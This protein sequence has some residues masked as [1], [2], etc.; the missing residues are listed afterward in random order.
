MSCETIPNKQKTEQSETINKNLESN[1][2]VVPFSYGMHSRT[3]TPLNWP[4]F[5]YATK[6]QTDSE[7]QKKRAH[8]KTVHKKSGC[9]FAFVNEGKSVVGGQKVPRLRTFVFM[10]ICGAE[11]MHVV[12][13]SMFKAK[14]LFS[15][16][17]HS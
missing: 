14:K 17:S 9:I 5:V 16:G 15:N 8:K 7:V 13:K 2:L 10:R 3:P 12:K 1:F 6:E 11:K 4:R